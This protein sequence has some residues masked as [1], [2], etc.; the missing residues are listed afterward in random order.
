VVVNVSYFFSFVD[1]PTVNVSKNSDP[2]VQRAAAML[3]ATAKFRKQVATGQLPYERVGRKKTPICAT[4]YKYMFNAC[5][6]PRREQDSYRIYDPSRYTHCIVA[7]NGHFFSIQLVHPETGNPL[8]VTEL[9]DQLRQC[10]A[11]AD[12]I[13]SSRPKLGLLTSGNRDD[14]A[15]ARQQLVITGGTAMR[16]ALEHLQSGAIL[17]NLDDEAPVSRQECGDLFWTGGLKSGENRWFDKS[18]QIM[19]ANNGKAGL[20]AEHSMMDGMPVI[21]F[22]DYVTKMTYAKAKRESKGG[23]SIGG[24]VVDIFADALREVNRETSGDLETKGW[25]TYRLMS[26]AGSLFWLH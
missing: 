3:F 9:E 13:P 2:N 18:I 17:L 8:S 15:D 22:A 14:W 19:V 4:A 21:R 7:R 10:I 6:I 11:L 25:S 26:N 12:A 5:R 24:Q 1:D 16:E 23:N 20:I